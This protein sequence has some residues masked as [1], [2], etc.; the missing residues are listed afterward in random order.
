MIITLTGA[1]GSGKSTIAKLLAKKLGFKHYSTGDFMRQMAED[2][3]M[4]LLE[5]GK[6]AETDK[7]IDTELDDRQVKIGKEEDDFVIDA[8]LGWHFIP[9]SKKIFLEVS[10]EEAARRI[11]TARRP[12]EQENTSMEQT[13]ENIKT[14][15]ES[16]KKRYMEYY[17]L[18]YHDKSNYDFV[19]D[20][21]ELTID[22]ALEKTLEFVNL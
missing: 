4:T 1:L 11:F 2:R 7:S 10:D 13:L 6:M 22:Q 16:E 21:T 19:L 17:G 12:E 8:R 3:G 20:T 18:D 14:R 15:R 9:H 5:L